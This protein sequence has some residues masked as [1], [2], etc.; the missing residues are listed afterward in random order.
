LQEHGDKRIG[1]VWKSDKE[2]YK[3]GDWLAGFIHST[4]P[5]L[6]EKA[7]FIDDASQIRKNG[8]LEKVDV[9]LLIDDATYSGRQLSLEAH[10]LSV[11]APGKPIYAAA[12]FSTNQA[13][14]KMLE[15]GKVKKFY[16]N[17]S[18]PTIEELL[19]R[20][21][22]EAK[23]LRA[24][25]I[26]M[27]GEDRLDRSLTILAHKIPDVRSALEEFTEG[28]VRNIDSAG[29]AHTEGTIRF[30]EGPRTSFYRKVKTE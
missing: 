7:V 22:A 18:M 19:Q 14:A 16:V 30:L 28:E 9:F 27:Y 21:G 11:W 5:P 6:G 24:N 3:S 8:T 10:E 13:Y 29:Y 2:Y 26:K 25:F 17:V 20:Q 4:F 15:H 23:S 12:A 1:V